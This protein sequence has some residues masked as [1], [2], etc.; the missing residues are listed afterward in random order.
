MNCQWLYK[1]LIPIILGFIC[2]FVVANEKVKSHDSISSIQIKELRLLPTSHLAFPDKPALFMVTN[3]G[4]VGTGLKLWLKAD[5]MGSYTRSAGGVWT[6]RSGNSNNAVNSASNNSSQVAADAILHPKLNTS[7]S[8]FNFNPTVSF[9]KSQMQINLG[10]KSTE[11]G[12]MET[13]VVVNGQNAIFGNGNS[14]EVERHMATHR[15]KSGNGSSNYTNFQGGESNINKLRILHLN[16]NGTSS[17]AATGYMS[18]NG[19]T[20]GSFSERNLDGGMAG[21]FHLGNAGAY[22]NF[23]GE[24]AEFIIYDS[25]QST[26]NRNKIFSYLGIKYGI[27][28]ESSGFDYINGGGTTIF[29]AAE[30]SGYTNNVF[31]I[32]NDSNSGLNQKYQK[33]QLHN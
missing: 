4:G 30:N 11:I 2:Q 26:A 14:N 29:E 7:T 5:D 20:I 28:I 6:D 13:F 24:I 19:G 22:G 9:N 31:G 3:P 8:L 33:I 12:S 18:V 27:P 21:K 32:G 23:Q 15:F 1:I 25:A 16:H 17:T 10:I